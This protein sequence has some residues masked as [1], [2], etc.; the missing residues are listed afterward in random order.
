MLNLF[1]RAQHDHAPDRPQAGA[2]RVAGRY[3]HSVGRL[4]FWASVDD[5]ALPRPSVARAGA[6]FAQA[7]T[8]SSEKTPHQV[9]GSADR[10]GLTHA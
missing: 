5:M 3:V 2:S 1:A 9:R 4:S 6:S 7:Q 8:L 10:G